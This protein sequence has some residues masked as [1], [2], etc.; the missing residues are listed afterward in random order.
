MP[1]AIEFAKTMDVIGFD[2]NEPKIHMYQQGIDPT[3][4]VGD[5][6]ICNSSMLYTS[7]ER[8]LR[9]VKFFVVAVPTPVNA[10]KTPNLEPVKLASQIVGRY[11]TPGCIVVYESTVYPGVTE[12]ICAKILEEESGMVCGKEFSLGYSPERI[13]PGDEKHRL[14]DIKKIVAGIDEKTTEEIARVY[15]AIIQA[16]IHKAG[17]IQVAEAAKVV[18]NSQRDINIAFMNELAIAFHQMKI[19]TREVLE[20]M[21]TKWNALGFTPGL[22]GG[23]CI[24]V[25][26]YYFLYQAEKV[27]YHSRIIAAGRK[28]NDD[29]GSFIAQAAIKR[30]VQQGILVREAKIG[31]FGV[32]FKENCPDTRNSKVI[33]IYHCLVDYGVVPV[34][35]DPV[36]D[37]EEVYREYDLSLQ[38]EAIGEPFDCCIFAVS[39]R[40]FDR[41]QEMAELDRL[42]GEHTKHQEIVI[43][44]KGMFERKK[45]E[46]RGYLY[47]RL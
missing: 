3:K 38:D 22:V 29:M 36:A 31:I 10:D 30:M 18:E 11:L 46:E 26:P 2:N 12:H 33:D 1:I 17:S 6:V 9:N 37:P 23:H 44:V 34:M 35:I 45:I 21:N 27:G 5:Q 43:D 16:G 28:I 25:D 4:E 15:G 19:D 47:W 14:P 40:E 24:G 7:D 32:T 8:E 13:N 20:A 41:Y 42:F 39:H